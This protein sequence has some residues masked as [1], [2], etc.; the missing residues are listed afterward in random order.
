MLVCTM[1]KYPSDA[2]LRAADKFVELFSTDKR[3]ESILLVGSCARGLATKDSCVDITV[4]LDDMGDSLHFETDANDKC[5]RT[6]EFRELERTG[7]FS[8]LDLNITD[9]RFKPVKRGWTSGPDNFELE[10]GN[11]FVH[12]HLLYDRRGRF[13]AL[14]ADFLPYYDEKLRR[15]RYEDVKRYLFNNLEHIPLCAHRGLHF[16]CLERLRNA[17]REYLQALF[18]SRRIYP[19]AYD[20]WI[21]E[22]MVE[23]L[24]MHRAYSDMVSLFQI[25]DLESGELEEKAALLRIMAERDLAQ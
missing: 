16:Q 7:K 5:L 23:M 8:N 25:G 3:V 2:H 24:G 19:I 10:I 15:T 14:R 12:S 1:V 11:T 17:S 20:K 18:I 9:G 21:K 22:Q 4:I 6:P 13:D